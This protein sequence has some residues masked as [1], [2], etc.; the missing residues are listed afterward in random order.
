MQ[1]CAKHFCPCATHCVTLHSIVIELPELAERLAARD[2]EL[3]KVQGEVESAH[4]SA[5]G[6]WLQVA[7]LQ[8]FDHLD[9]ALF[10]ICVCTCSNGILY[11]W[12]VLC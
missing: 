6:E 5:A 2:Q 9:E 1:H 10:V 7:L 8:C 11:I 4:A 12:K 3:L